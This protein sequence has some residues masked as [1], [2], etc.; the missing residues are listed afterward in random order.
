MTKTTIN[1][2]SDVG[3]IMRALSDSN[4]GGQHEIFLSIM[5]QSFSM[6]NE[7]VERVQARLSQQ[8]NL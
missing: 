3:L 4:S 1:P 6:F 2:M 7:A 5:Q 8:G